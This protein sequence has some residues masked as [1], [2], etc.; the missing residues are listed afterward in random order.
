MAIAKDFIVKNG[1]QIQGVGSNPAT[2]TGTGA[3]IVSGGAGFNGDIYALN[4]FSN[5]AEVIT[6]AT[7]DIFG[8]IVQSVTGGTDIS[9]N[10]TTGHV[11]VNN[12]S[13]LQ[14]VTDR[15]STTTNAI[16]ITNNTESNNTT[17][18]ALVVTGGVGIGG[19]VNIAGDLTVSGMINAQIDGTITTATNLAG[20]LA[21]QIPFQTAAGLTGFSSDLIFNDTSKLF[22]AGKANIYG[23]TA[24]G[25]GL[26]SSTTVS[27]EADTG[28]S[29]QLMSDSLAQ[30]NYNN[31]GFVK[32]GSAGAE[33]ISS[34]FTATWASGELT[35]SGS[36]TSA[37][38]LGAGAL[39][40]TGGAYLSDNL[41]A[42][43]NISGGT[44]TGR[45]LTNGRVTYTKNNE[46][47]DSDNLTFDDITLRF[48]SL[49]ASSA[50]TFQSTVDITSTAT[51]NT[52]T[53]GA[54]HVAGGVG[55]EGSLNV[56]E[57]FTVHG[58]AVFNNPVT[59]NGTAT[60]VYSSNSFYTDN[61]VELH[62]FTST[63]VMAHWPF[64]DGKDIGYRF[65]YFNRTDNTGTSAALILANDSQWLEWY[66]SGAEGTST[67]AGASYGGF[68]LGQIY[69]ENTNN[70]TTSSGS[71]GSAALQVQGGA[72]IVKD[73]WVGG[74][75]HQG[76]N[77]VVDTGN[78]ENYAVTSLTAGDDL[79]VNT[80]VGSV[81]ISST[82][83]LQSVTNRGATTNN[84][85]SIT[86]NTVGANTNSGQAL[87]VSGGIG[88]LKVVASEVYSR[89]EL[90]LN[91]VQPAGGT[92]I[93]IT[94]VSTSNGVTS[95]TINNTGVTALTAGT[96]ISIN[97][98][99][100][101]IT[102]GNTS[103]LQS[104][105]DRGSTT[106]NTIHLTNTASS[107]SSIAGNALVVAGGIGASVVY[108]DQLF[109]NNQTVITTGTL[110]AIITAG[111][112]ISVT[113]S[114][115]ELIIAN[116]GVIAI[117]SGTDISLT[118]TG[119]GRYTIN[120]TSTLQS[121]TGRG[122][123][124]SNAINITNTTASTNT[125]TG[126]LKVSGGVGVGGNINAGGTVGFGPAAQAASYS[127]VSTNTAALINLD[128][129]VAA[130]YRTA[131]Y[132]VQVVD[133][134]K[135]QATELL[136]FHDDTN[137]YIIRYAIG[138]S[139]D[140]M[141]EWDATLS[142]GT[143]TLQFTPSYNP[144]ALTVKTLRTVISA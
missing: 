35:L 58:P 4:M 3:L 133:G 92:A 12:I 125:S 130:D 7:L 22:S 27:V 116:T 21:T 81:V 112:G 78:I 101:N 37:S 98:T 39:K 105:T 120:D 135:V 95:F 68:K 55:I 64:D 60:Y 47:T 28:N 119:T 63:D 29:I 15:G 53:N 131:K 117:S 33:I 143:V 1:V 128:S 76:V 114:G 36:G 66:G 16:Y 137:A 59:F 86:N 94:S 74:T 109:A 118:L 49:I 46:I 144:T 88:A 82:A 102:V 6:T 34:G 31:S 19:N 136:V 79:S 11:T 43:N 99:T 138:Y 8:G 83:T 103:T 142:G 97:T 100:G 14:T 134:T 20:G 44:L 61:M 17:S 80:S 5:G 122:G 54:L 38:N 23:D 24:S 77:L 132:V 126:A 62:V 124:T 71:F 89:G 121:V 56:G 123:S 18:G 70:A 48:P 108:A 141:G 106:T 42:V 84:A 110:E 26:S 73:L 57:F 96:D 25:S 9:V 127:S 67:F 40:V 111:D 140:E 91:Q 2:S 41:Y 13:T 113:P 72:G 115:T 85:I 93:S 69:L 65:H 51:S 32:I 30:L 139:Q 45:N 75:I 10:T 107:T 87:L 129:Y 104:V 90:V 52:T 50:S